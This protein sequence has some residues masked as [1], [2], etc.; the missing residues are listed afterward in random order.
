MEKTYKFKGVLDR[1]YSEINLFQHLGDQY[2]VPYQ[3]G[4][5]EFDG[6]KEFPR[7]T[8]NICDI[9]LRIKV[10]DKPEAEERNGE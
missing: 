3:I 7:F 4:Y 8:E 5:I 10:L 6:L 2:D 9:E 1:K